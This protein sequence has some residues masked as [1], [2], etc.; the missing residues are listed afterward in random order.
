LC[1]AAEL[2]A[3][4]NAINAPAIIPSKIHLERGSFAFTS[5]PLR[6]APKTFAGVLNPLSI[7]ITP[8]KY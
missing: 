8:S 7:F 2:V 3:P 1:T 4:P 6:L 5:F